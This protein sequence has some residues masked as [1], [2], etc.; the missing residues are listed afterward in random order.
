MKKYLWIIALLACF[1]TANA[2]IDYYFIDYEPFTP[3]QQQVLSN[4]DYVARVDYRSHT[5]YTAQYKL[6]V[7]V[8]NDCVVAIY[9]GNGG[10]IHTGHNNEG[11]EFEGG[12]LKPVTD[13]YGD[14]VA[15]KA[16]IWVSYYQMD[17]YALPQHLHD[18]YSITIE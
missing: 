4:G 14:I 12:K 8:E 3:S 17:E 10:S 5:G 11:Y 2:Q 16:T 9:F 7:R 6:A 18:K 15:M 1:T 13:Y